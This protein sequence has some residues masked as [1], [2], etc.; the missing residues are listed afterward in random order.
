MPVDFN[1]IGATNM[2]LVLALKN[3]IAHASGYPVTD[4]LHPEA[5]NYDLS[6]GLHAIANRRYLTGSYT[7]TKYYCHDG[8]D[9]DMKKRIV[10]I[11]DP[12]HPASPQT[13]YRLIHTGGPQGARDNSYGQCD[14]IANIP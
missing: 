11:H 8:F 5:Y 6:Y 14:L 3:G 7:G 1:Q 4:Y 9:W 13:F 2:A 12:L 10:H